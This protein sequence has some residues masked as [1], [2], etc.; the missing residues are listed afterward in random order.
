M[1]YQQPSFSVPSTTP[2]KTPC[3]VHHIVKG[4]CLRCD[5]TVVGVTARTIPDGYECFTATPE[6]R[7]A[8]S[9]SVPTD[10]EGAE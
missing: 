3:A 10:S 2:S 1:K 6:G 7:Q 9:E 4:K 8:L 5:H